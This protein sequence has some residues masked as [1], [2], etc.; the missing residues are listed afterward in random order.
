V[1]AVFER[2]DEHGLRYFD[3]KIHFQGW[4]PSYDRSVRAS[5]LLKDSEENRQLQREL[6]EAAQLQ[7]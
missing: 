5:V 2:T 4:R 1:L 3:Y 7:M 6:A